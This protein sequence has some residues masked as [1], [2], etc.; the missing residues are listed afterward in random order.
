MDFRALL[1]PLGPTAISSSS[2]SYSSLADILVFLYSLRNP[3]ILLH[4]TGDSSGVYSM[5]LEDVPDYS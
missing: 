1:G 3:S 5:A 4:S 2:S